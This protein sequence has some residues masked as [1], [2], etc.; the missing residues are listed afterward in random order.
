LAQ[1]VLLLDELV[2]VGDDVVVFHEQRRYAVGCVV[3]RWRRATR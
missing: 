2:D 3:A 1:L